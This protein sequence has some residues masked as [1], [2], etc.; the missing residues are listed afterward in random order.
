LLQALWSAWLKRL[1]VISA[2]V[3]VFARLY[4]VTTRSS[5]FYPRFFRGGAMANIRVCTRMR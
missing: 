2:F 4:H 1:V 5:L 3:W